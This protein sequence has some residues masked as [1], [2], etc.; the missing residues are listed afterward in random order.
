MIVKTLYLALAFVL[1]TPSYAQQSG[2][3]IDRFMKDITACAAGYKGANERLSQVS[4]CAIV[5]G[6]SELAVSAHELACSSKRYSPEI[7][8]HYCPLGLLELAVFFSDPVNEERDIP[9][10][11]AYIGRLTK[12]FPESEPAKVAGELLVRLR[13]SK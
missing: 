13:E 6:K 5:K 3:D 11:L 12:E 1:S 9:R 2:V 10:S 8:A 7:R 4:K